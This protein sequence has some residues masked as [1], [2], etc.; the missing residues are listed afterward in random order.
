MSQRNVDD[1]SQFSETGLFQ[2]VLS[3]SLFTIRQLYLEQEASRSTTVKSSVLAKMQEFRDTLNAVASAI[4]P[5]ELFNETVRASSMGDAATEISDMQSLLSR[6]RDYLELNWRSNVSWMLKLYPRKNQ[7]S[8]QMWLNRLSSIQETAVAADAAKQCLTLFISMIRP[9]LRR[10]SGSDRDFVLCPEPSVFAID[11]SVETSALRKVI[12]KQDT[13]S[14]FTDAIKDVL[15]FLR[16]VHPREKVATGDSLLITPFTRIEQAFGRY[17][18]VIGRNVNWVVGTMIPHGMFGI[19][20]GPNTHATQSMAYQVR[21]IDNLNFTPGLDYK[22]HVVVVWHTSAGVAPVAGSLTIVDNSPA[23]TTAVL[24]LTNLANSF[25][26]ATGT[27]DMGFRSTGATWDLNTLEWGFAWDVTTAA[28]ST[29]YYTVDVSLWSS[30]PTDREISVDS[31]VSVEAASTRLLRA[32]E[33]WGTL[34]GTQKPV[35]PFVDQ[36]FC[37]LGYFDNYVSETSSIKLACEVLQAMIL[38]GIE[39]RLIEDNDVTFAAG[40]R[41]KAGTNA[42]IDLLAKWPANLLLNT[43]PLA[44]AAVPLNLRDQ[45]KLFNSLSSMFSCLYDDYLYGDLATVRAVESVLNFDL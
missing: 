25:G 2:S 28:G 23:A 13:K 9:D 14:K 7:E 19:E 43:G 34:Y 3:D 4:F 36:D 1:L 6:I 39:F 33:K 11:G 20:V 29:G 40:F 35:F 8:V 5:G 15:A 42:I 38:D 26:T 17:V 22:L 30:T 45:V 10:A 44:P 37:V 32:D 27:I 12:G 18:A 31:L 24:T 41:G 21:Q 16:R